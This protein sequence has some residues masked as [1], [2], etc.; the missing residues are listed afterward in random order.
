VQ[1][2]SQANGGNGGKG[3]VILAVP[4]SQYTG[5]YTGSPSITTNG[6]YTILTFSGTGTY[7]T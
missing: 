7:K 6:S 2:N 1:A 5:T 3:T 4:T